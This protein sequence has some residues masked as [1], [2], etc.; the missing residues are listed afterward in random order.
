[1]EKLAILGGT[2]AIPKDVPKD[3]FRWPIITEEDEA[4]ALDV[5]RNN[6]FSGTDITI[7][8]QEEFAAWI[9][10]RHALAFT[11]GTMSLSAAMFAIGL[12]VGDEIICPTKTYWG[13]VTGAQWFGATP[14][15]CA[16][17]NK[18]SLDPN[19]LERCITDKTKA[20]M[21][22]HYHGYPCD[23]DPI[24]E[25]ANRHNLYVIEDVSHAQGTL[26]KGKKVGTFGH[27]AGMSMMSGKAFA[28]GELGMLV[29][30]DTKLYERAL[31]YGHYERNNADFIKESEDLK[32]YFH[33]AVGSVKGRA[34][35]LCCALARGQ[36]AHYD[37]RTAEIRRAMNYFFDQLEKIPG[38]TP[39]RV[40]EST[41]STMG[42][43]YHP[44]AI[45]DENAFHGLSVKR[46]AKAVMDEF[47]GT[48]PC[49]DG[50]NY[51]LHTHSYF[52]TFDGFNL[53]RPSRI[54]FSDRKEIPN[55]DAVPS[56][57]ASTKVYCFSV[58][59]FKQLDREW[60][61]R[62]V[63][64]FRKVADNHMALLEGD[65]KGEQGGRWHGT[66]NEENQ[67]KK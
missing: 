3:L 36:L 17:N 52:K 34:N 23:M 67:Q 18:M 12:G 51:C 41:G 48:A 6:K 60:I 21:V 58:P 33:V 27:V 2:P 28:A 13:S 61:D 57:I 55:D 25:I 8:F 62:Y 63:A 16:I 38:I 64:A 19:D 56:L 49:W 37:E 15:F 53:G 32:P 54:A 9:G 10:R 20:I 66:T 11:N 45:Y 59:W 46:F 39:L 30:D 65:D 50:A 22:V 47:N 26:Y 31:A 43:F 1:M 40:D 42:G 35:Q 5:I 44:H 4:A 29:T 24:M 7:K 14:I